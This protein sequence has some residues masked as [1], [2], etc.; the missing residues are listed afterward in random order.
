MIIN[1]EIN[2]SSNLFFFYLL[3]WKSY[4]MTIIYDKF[5]YILYVFDYLFNVEYDNCISKNIN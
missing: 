1:N 4:Y 3:C 5:N 2:L